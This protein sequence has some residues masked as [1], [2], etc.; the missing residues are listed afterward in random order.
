[1]KSTRLLREIIG[2]DQKTLCEAAGLARQQLSMYEN[3]YVFPSRRVCQRIDDAIEKIIDQRALAAA[4]A[5][6][7]VPP[8][9]ELEDDGLIGR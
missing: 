2:I 1:M 8:G 4:E 3:G 7:R 5:L 6:R 9:P